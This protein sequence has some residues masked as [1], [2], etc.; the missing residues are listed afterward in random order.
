MHI[1]GNMLSGHVVPITNSVSLAAIAAATYYAIKAKN[2]PTPLRFGAVAALIVALQMMN[3][4]V[5]DGTSGH[6]LG[7]VLAVVLLGAP[8]GI[9]AMGFVLAVQS[10]VFADGGVYMLGANVLNMAVIGGLVGAGIRKISSNNFE[11]ANLRDYLLLGIGAWVSTVLAALL[12]SLELA[13]AGVI[14]F[15]KIV[16]AMLGTH[17]LIGI[18][19]ALISVSVFA[20]VGSSAISNRSKKSYLVP[21]TLASFIALV[22]SP[23]TSALPDG[24]EWVALKF[25]FI[26]NSISTY[27]TPFAD[28]T[29]PFVNNNVIST[30]LTGVAG[31]MIT[32]VVV[33]F[34]GKQFNNKL[35]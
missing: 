19:E 15:N 23:F 13:G 9:L 7:A 10:F 4:A 26:S 31:V 1:P 17:V 12:C 27:I 18:G 29:F 21:L 5:Q 2:K 30:S 25:G 8:F 35:V 16:F 24:L 3:F 33:W 32:F 14:E 11:N 34:A 6:L 20:F 22:I 28:Y